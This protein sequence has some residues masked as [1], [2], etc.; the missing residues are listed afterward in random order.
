MKNELINKEMKEILKKKK[1]CL[2]W[3]EVKEELRVYES[4]KQVFAFFSQA[5][6][7]H[8]LPSAADRS[9]LLL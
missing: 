8:V 6:I 4:L 2:L 1:S 3:G 7:L 9:L 5:T